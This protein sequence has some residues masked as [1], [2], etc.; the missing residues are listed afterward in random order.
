[1]IA[2]ETEKAKII[3]LK[4]EK[5]VFVMK[6]SDAEGIKK[7][8]RLLLCWWINQK[9]WI[10]LTYQSIREFFD[11]HIFLKDPLVNNLRNE[12]EFELISRNPGIEPLKFK[13]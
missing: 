10:S 13:S 12:R 5:N 1:M 7:L 11:I 8:R 6:G 2:G 9:H 4:I 3:L